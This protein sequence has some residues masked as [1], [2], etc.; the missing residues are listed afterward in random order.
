[1]STIIGT[2]DA[3][4]L[5]GGYD[6][7]TLS[8]M[9]GNDTLRGGGGS[10]LLDGG[11]GDDWLYGVSGSDTLLGGD[12]DDHLHVAAILN[13]Y[14]QVDGGAG[15]DTLVVE[16]SGS[17]IVDLAASQIERV[18]G[19]DGNDS[20]SNHFAATAVEIDAGAGNDN[21]FGGNGNDTL[22]GDDGNDTING[23]LGADVIIGGDGID[24][25][26]FMYSNE[27]VTVD[28]S[29]GIGVGGHAEGDLLSGIENLY[30]SYMSDTLTGDSGDN[31]LQGGSGN[32]TLSGGAGNDTL[33]GDF[34]NDVLIGSA[35]ADAF[36][37]N[38]F[39]GNADVILDFESGVDRIEL[40]GSSFGLPDGMLDAGL[41][42]LDAPTDADDRFIFDTA[43]GTLSY[44][45]DGSGSG[46]A[47]VMATLNVRT[48]SASDIVSVPYQPL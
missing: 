22:C 44:D 37:F 28:L 12:G 43:T 48:L 33:L 17:I 31:K 10:D 23:G 24:L 26:S 20:Y 39:F 7:D 21:L 15:F 27:A 14:N 34:G 47:V 4:S 30:G 41:F 3:D 8:G 6:A 45:A 2:A 5:T 46:A 19:G 9:E 38:R 18:Y 16:G 11:A 36:R 13:H 32:D 25:A 29:T 35:G 42:A 40:E 1:M